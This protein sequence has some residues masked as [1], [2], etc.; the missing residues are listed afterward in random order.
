M[1]AKRHARGFAF[2][3][4]GT[5]TVAGSADGI[6][7]AVPTDSDRDERRLE[8]E[9]N[10]CAARRHAIQH[11]GGPPVRAQSERSLARLIDRGGALSR[12][13]GRSQR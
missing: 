11:T 9:A 8:A 5:S 12:A 1:A 4:H 13:T 10:R 7:V 6:F 2:V 3:V